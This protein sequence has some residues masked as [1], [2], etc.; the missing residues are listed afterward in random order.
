MRLSFVTFVSTKQLSTQSLLIGPVTF[1]PAEEES[2]WV[3]SKWIGTIWVLKSQCFS[4]L[5]ML[6]NYCH[7]AVSNRLL[8][9]RSQTKLIFFGFFSDKWKST[10]VLVRRCFSNKNEWIYYSLKGWGGDKT[11]TCIIMFWKHKVKR[12]SCQ[13]SFAIKLSFVSISKLEEPSCESLGIWSKKLSH[14]LALETPRSFSFLG[15]QY[16]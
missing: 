9:V 11:P 5:T 8:H 14:S 4:C 13:V 2:G 6:T 1:Q 12:N 7:L 16:R 10:I 15:P 3:F